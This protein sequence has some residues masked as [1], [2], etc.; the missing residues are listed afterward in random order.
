ML[1][2]VSYNKESSGLT[3]SFSSVVING[4]LLKKKHK[5]LSSGK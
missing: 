2:D 5:G 1:L 3:S 4:L